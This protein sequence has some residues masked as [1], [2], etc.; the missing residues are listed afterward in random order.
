M[1]MPI[2]TWLRRLLTPPTHRSAIKDG[3]DASTVIIL[4][5]GPGPMFSPAKAAHVTAYFAIREGGDIDVLKLAKL[6]YLAE[7]EHLDVYERPL[8]G[9]TLVAMPHGP[10]PSLTLDHV[11]GCAR[12]DAR[13]DSVVDDRGAYRVGL[14]NIAM[15]LDDLALSASER[16]ILTDVYDRFGDLD[17]FALRDFTHDHCPEWTDP[18]GS[19]RRIELPVLLAALGKE[20]VKAIIERMEHSPHPSNPEV[21][22]AEAAIVSDPDVMGG[23][24]V[25]KGTRV[26][27]YL[28]AKMLNEG[29]DREEILSGYPSIDAGKLALA[30][31]F[32]DAYPRRSEPRQIRNHGRYG[33]ANHGP[34]TMHRVGRTG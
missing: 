27:A 7:R 31:T 2:L 16:S 9:D 10:A 3:E 32:A 30:K 26:P 34:S 12:G 20:D 25:F 24:P 14:K 23:E 4:R 17:G 6:V 33:S 28:I 18:E 19:S 29:V 13:W 5:S 15:T 8:T 11:N 21:E 1:D 22:A